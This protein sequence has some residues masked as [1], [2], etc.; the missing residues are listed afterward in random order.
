M[1][2]AG[3]RHPDRP[4]IYCGESDEAQ[5][6]GKWLPEHLADD[7]PQKLKREPKES[8]FT[9]WFWDGTEV[10]VQR[11]RVDYAD[12]RPKDVRWAG[13]LNGRPE[14]EIQPYLWKESTTRLATD[15]GVLFVVRGELK[16]ELLRS[17]GHYAISI[18]GISERLIAEL[19]RLGPD[20]VLCPDCDLAD[21][22]KWYAELT[23]QLPQ[24]RHLLSPMQGSELET[25]AKT[26][27]AW[28]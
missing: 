12:Y 2:A 19:R 6:F 22:N 27:W 20:V 8:L 5:G 1:V 28:C 25:T 14:T 4:Y 10:P 17:L 15:G 24:C 3:E 7:R 11:R 18:L 23:R 9:Y 21:L 16:A 26:Q 13:T